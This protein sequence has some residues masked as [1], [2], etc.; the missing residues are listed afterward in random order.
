MTKPSKKRLVVVDDDIDLRE[1][2]VAYFGDPYEVD[3]YPGTPAALQGA[4]R[5][6]A[7][8]PAARHRPAA[9]SRASTS[10]RL[11]NSTPDLRAAP[12]IVLSAT[13]D[14]ETFEQAHRL[15][16]AEYVTKPFRVEDL[17]AKLETRD[18]PPPPAQRRAASS[19]A[20]CSSRA[21]SSRRRSS[22]TP[23]SA[24][25]SDGGRLGEVLVGVGPR[26]RGGPRS[27][28][29]AGQMHIGRGRPARRH[30]QP[31]RRRPAAARLHRAPPPAAAA[32]R[33]GRQPGARHD[34]PARRRRP[35]TRSG[36]APSSSVVPVICTESA[37]DEALVDLSRARAAS[38][39]SSTSDAR[40][41]D[42][43]RAA[44]R[45][46]PRSSR[47]STRSL[48]RRHRHEGLRHPP[49]AA[50][51]RSCRSAAGST[52][53]CTTCASTPSSCRPA[54]SAASRSWPTWTSP[55]GACPRTAAPASRLA[56]ATSSTCASPR[57]PAS[58]ARTSRSASSRSRRCR[59]RSPR[60][61]S[62]ETTWRA[63][64]RP[65]SGPTAASSSSGPTGSG[66]ST[67][68]YTTLELIKSPERKIYTVEDPI[69]RKLHGIVQTE[70]KPI[71]GLTFAQALRSLVRADPDVIM[72]GEVRDLE[73]AKM[74]ADAAITGHLVFTTLHTDDAVSSINRLVE[75]GLPRLPGGRGL[76]L[77]RRAAAGA[78]PV[79]P[80]P[81]PEVMTAARWVE[82]G[83]GE[84]PGSA[85][86]HLRAGRLPQVLRHRVLRPPRALRG[87]H[88]RRR[89]ARDDRRR[90][91][92]SARCAPPPASAA[93]RASATTACAR[94]STARPAT[95][96]SCASPRRAGRRRP[97]S[98]PPARQAATRRQRGR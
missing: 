45:S 60:W 55:S 89:A 85:H 82:L 94:C 83:L 92:P 79:P 52:A 70:V 61:A 49:R 33:R 57:S 29:L 90:R 53:C 51:G 65:S 39:R 91:P 50:R 38:S 36:C 19:S 46:T 23:C 66:K 98:T 64:R 28:P 14:F 40:R 54:S 72:V 47:S 24:S 2:L 18:R 48:D 73:T 4:A 96:S 76:P 74:A 16:I 97:R 42:G 41:D 93:S 20:P 32:P 77:H 67:T 25:S 30:A 17:R 44:A 6:A 26:V 56:T 35:S 80:L 3:T 78:P 10:C 37:F 88:R 81:R 62:P 58:T 34:Q 75:M 87:A 59:R 21:A 8:R 86:R 9:A 63:S 84:A 15:G 71:I 12:V 27:T 1:E 22:T 43:R 13:N 68:L 31:R 5:G 95:S 69:E 7:R 11:M